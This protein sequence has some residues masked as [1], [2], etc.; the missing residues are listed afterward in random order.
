MKAYNC[1][2]VLLFVTISVVMS[3]NNDSIS[4][5]KVF[6]GRLFYQGNRQLTINDIEN[7]VKS[8]EVAYKEFKS[9]KAVSSFT[10]ILSYAG[11][12]LIGWPLGT[13]IGGGEP[14]W[15]LAYI[16]TGLVAVSIPFA[17]HAN[18]KLN[19]SVLI[20]NKGITTSSTTTKGELKLAMTAGGLGLVF[21]F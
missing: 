6:G 10:Y 19:N 20:Y 2:L 12:F 13:A 18:K 16:G 9:A 3:Q 1:I 7:A 14:M 11:G 17:I 8:N 5:R 4:S 15:E 21:K